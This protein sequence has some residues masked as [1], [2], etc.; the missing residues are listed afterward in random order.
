MGAVMENRWSDDRAAQFVEKYGG[1]WGSDLAIGLYLASLIG[2]DD[3]LVLHGGGNSSVKTVHTNILGERLNAIYVKASGYNMAFIEPNGYTGLDLD[4]LRKL[5]VLSELSDEDMVNEF[6]THFLNARAATPSI[7]TLVHVFIPSKFVDHTH[8]DSILSLTNQ[9]G[10]GK[11]VGEALGK[12][13]VVLEYFPPGFKLA[14]AIADALESNPKA[15]AIVLMRH[16]LVTWGATARESYGKML[17]LT[18]KAERYIEQH[19]RNPVT[20]TVSTPV[21]IGEKRYLDIAPLVRGLLANRTCDSDNPWAR[22]ILRPLITKDVLDL[23]G[24]DR[25]REIASTPPL[26]SDH[27]IRTKALYLWVGNPSFEDPPKLREQFSKAIQDYAVQ[28]DSYVD[29]YAGSIP[30]G[31][32]RM[33]SFPRV[34]LVPGLGAICAGKDIAAAEIVRDITAHTLATK[35]QIAAMGTY[36]GMSEPELFEMEYRSLQHV[37]LQGE[38]ALPLARSV[39]LITG[40]AGAIGSG[41]AQE[42]L[43]QGCHV[44]ITDLPGDALTGLADELRN[45]FGSRVMAVPL[46]ITDPESISA[47]FGAVIRTWGGIDL[48]VLNA[49]VA[50]V[51]ALTEMNLESFRK[52]EKINVEGTLLMLAESARVFKIQGTGGDIVLV[53]TKNVFAPGAKFGAYSATKAAG[54]QLARIASQEFAAMNVRVNMV[55]PDAVFSHGSRKS[56]LWTEIGP[57]RM[58]ARG[59]NPEGLEEYYRNRN[60][61]RARVTAQH[62]AKAVLYFATRQSPTTGA[63]IPVDGGL[64]DATPR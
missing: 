6:R 9:Q 41:I 34:I 61:L 24:S 42:L 29:R 54:H 50:H 40:A 5:R 31:V 21:S 55:A 56:G 62:V 38:K 3:T 4:Y 26:T 64:P 59:L 32:E 45:R 43:D 19:S 63:T 23:V 44:A 1:K 8:P 51:S 39:A 33:D 13:V 12:N 18:G 14:K 49:G 16:G 22:V 20:S 15:E 47:G 37:K 36:C 17:D 7:E 58:A 35:A 2:A 48:F 11:I 27:L 52:L 10:G 25:G 60:L 53:S 57:D 28:Y 30:P 46:D